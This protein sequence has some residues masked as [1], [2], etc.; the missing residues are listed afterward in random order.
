M[1]A[2]ASVVVVVPEDVVGLDL[3]RLHIREVDLFHG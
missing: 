1:V 2:V 3:R